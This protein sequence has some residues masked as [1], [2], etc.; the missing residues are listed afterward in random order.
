MCYLKEHFSRVFFPFFM[1]S[2][3]SRIELIL[4][5][6]CSL[7]A[8]LLVWLMVLGKG[9]R[10]KTSND[11]NW[12]YLLQILW[13]VNLIELNCQWCRSF[14]FK[15]IQIQTVAIHNIESAIRLSNKDV[16]RVQQFVMQGIYFL[17]PLNCLSLVVTKVVGSYDFLPTILCHRS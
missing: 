4:M 6:S 3:A 7:C 9:R 12:A 11:S 10:R 15:G 17:K 13:K 14:Q 1:P 16:L 8:L 5:Q 2:F